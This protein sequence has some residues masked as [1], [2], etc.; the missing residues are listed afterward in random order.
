MTNIKISQDFDSTRWLGDVVLNAYGKNVFEEMKKSG[1]DM[2]IAPAFII[3]KQDPD[4]TI[5]EVEL[6]SMSVIPA[7]RAI[8]KEERS[9][10]EVEV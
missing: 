4:G 1:V 7:K 2:V 3:K 9:D 10:D 8:K 6:I 5:L